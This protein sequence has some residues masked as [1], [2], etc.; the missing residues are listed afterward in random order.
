[1]PR[2]LNKRH[3]N[4]KDLPNVVYVGRPSK[5]GNPFEI[6]VDGDREMVVRK[7]EEWI[8]N[9]LKEDPEFIHEIID[10]L[11]GKDL[12]CWCAP[13]LCHAETLMRIANAPGEWI[14]RVPC[15]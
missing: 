4:T 3:I 8:Y 2:V 11:Q 7:H 1:M 15:G 12:A 14:G 6:G 5:W 10:E 9:K 13:L